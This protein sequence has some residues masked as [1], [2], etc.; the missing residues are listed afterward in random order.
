MA[1]EV[2]WTPQA[3]ADYYSIIQYLEKFWNTSIAYDFMRLTERRL[4]SLAEQP[5]LGL[6]SEKQPEVRS[7]LLTKHNRLYIKTKEPS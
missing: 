7:T 5:L 2:E 1:Q 3:L 4:Q 6:G